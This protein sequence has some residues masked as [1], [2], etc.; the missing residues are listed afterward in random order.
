M[1][2]DDTGRRHGGGSLVPAPSALAAVGVGTA[3]LALVLLGLNLRVVFGSASATMTE[4]RQDYGLGAGSAALVTTGPVLC[5][6]V[7][8]L[9]G[10]R[11]LRRWT[12]PV[13]LTGCLVAVSVG[14]ALR[15]APWWS[16]LVFGTVVAGIGVAIAN[17]LGPVLIRLL[18][19]HRI[20]SMTGLFTAL[21][22]ASAGLAA[23]V[24][25]PIDSALFHDWRVTLMAWSIPSALAVAAMAL[26]SWRYRVVA[27]S[28]TAG[29][30]TAATTPV[31]DLVRSPVARAVTGFMGLQ[32]LLAY[33]LIAWLPTVY[34]DR[35]MAPDH[36]GL[37]LTSL[38]VSSIATALTVPV[39]ATRLRRQSALAVTVVALSVAGLTGVLVGDT[40]MATVSA[41]LLGLGQGGQLSLALTLM[42][43]RSR[44]AATTTSLSTM[45]QSIGYLVAALGPV[46]SGAIHGATGTWTVPLV[47][48]VVVTV[49]MAVCGWVAGR[50]T[51]VRDTPSESPLAS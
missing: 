6:G 1:T 46:V 32:S 2:D 40:G 35:G 37:V 4:I 36:A 18:F 27:Q 22:S 30:R 41:V 12:V 14:T 48:L 20:G 16:S 13:V 31:T 47:A 17:V 15:G 23:G 21:V 49:P 7:F 10:P 50:D 34:R 11:L 9:A 8:A 33:S 26:L 39:L 29:T 45:A 42:N 43:L 28:A 51:P 19:P 25:V 5:L 3:V 38:S 44:S 24:T